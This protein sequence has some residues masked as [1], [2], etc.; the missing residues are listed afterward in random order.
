MISPRLRWKLARQW[1]RVQSTL[2]NL[3]RPEPKPRVCFSCGRLVGANEKVCSN[4]GASQAPLSLSVFKRVALA[5][6][7][8]ENP[9]TYALLFGNLLFFVVA[10]IITVRGGGDL[11]LFSQL[12]SEVLYRLGAKFGYDILVR[13]EVWRLVMPIFLHFDLLHFAFNSFVLWQ[14]G[15]QVEELFGSARYLYLYL[16][17][18]VVGFVAS[19]WWY[20]ILGR[21]SLSA[22]SSGAL[23]GL[24][25]ILISYISQ[26]PGF[27]SEYRASLIRWAIFIII[28]GFFLSFDNAAHIGGLLSGL[29]LGRLVS[30]RRPA[31]PAARLRVALMGW[32]SLAVIFLS[33]LMVLLNLPSSPS[34]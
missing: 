34:P 1:E 5:V 10:W 14:V 31:T 25:G 16:V 24:I 2:Q 20:D 33:I 13:G 23:F 11:G 29:A 9:V 17:T 19:L 28:I 32:G 27:A 7:P 3:L 30:A 15:P 22:G 8:A 26:R 21:P 4:C 12:N 6:I 18:G